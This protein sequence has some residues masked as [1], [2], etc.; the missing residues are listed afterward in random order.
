MDC[1]LVLKCAAKVRFF[2]HRASRNFNTPAGRRDQEISQSRV[3]KQARKAAKVL[4]VGRLQRAFHWI[5]LFL[6]LF[7]TVRSIDPYG[8][9]GIYPELFLAFCSF[10]VSALLFTGAVVSFL[11]PI[12]LVYSAMLRPMPLLFKKAGTVL[13]GTMFVVANALIIAML[14]AGSRK[15]GSGVYTLSLAIGFFLA[16]VIF[17][18][19]MYRI[20]RDVHRFLGDPSGPNSDGSTSSIPSTVA[21]S[22]MHVRTSATGSDTPVSPGRKTRADITTGNSVRKVVR[23]MSIYQVVATILV[24]LQNVF[25]IVQNMNLAHDGNDG[26]DKPTVYADVLPQFSFRVI[27]LVAHIVTLWYAWMPLSSLCKADEDSD[28]E[29]DH[30]KTAASDV[31][32]QDLHHSPRTAEPVAARLAVV[33]SDPAFLGSL[34]TVTHSSMSQLGRPAGNSVVESASGVRRESESWTGLATVTAVGDDATGLNT[35][36]IYIQPTVP[37]W[38]PSLESAVDPDRTRSG[39]TVTD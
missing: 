10:N 34:Q 30:V 17:N 2:T 28:T 16:A 36:S 37:A 20:R 22:Q 1:V 6:G 38:R 4:R 26:Y 29:D 11:F 9:V 32:D 31:H 35:T 12:E 39:S 14:A 24:L 8:A 19:Y 27:Q 5:G 18:L 15:W 7:Q 13:G 33:E 23:K 25:A 3:I 21:P